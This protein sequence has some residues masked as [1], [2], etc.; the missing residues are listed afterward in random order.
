MD[1]YLPLAFALVA[2]IGAATPGPTV[3]LALVNGSRFGV[4]GALPGMIGAM[5]SDLVLVGAVAAGLGALLMASEF[6]FTVVKWVGAGY[7]AWL[8]I[9]MLRSKGSIGSLPGIEGAE[10]L[11]AWRL[12]SKSFLVAVTNPKGYIFFS[13]LL[14]QFIVPSEPQAAQYLTLALI[15]AGVDLV[16]MLGYALAGSQAMR[17]LKERGARWLDRVCGGMLITL[18]A[19]LALYRRAA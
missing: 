12:F 15:S 14:P 19:S 8:G 16:V 4:A 6:W 1:H 13:A 3:L 7:L 17:F 2:F 9:Q 11:S 18:A 10:R 5:L